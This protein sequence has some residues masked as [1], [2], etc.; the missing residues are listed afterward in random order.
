MKP[1]ALLLTLFV[2]NLWAGTGR[3]VTF[4]SGSPMP[5]AYSASNSQSFI[6]SEILSMSNISLTNSSSYAI[7][8]IFSNNNITPVNG[9]GSGI[10]SVE[11][12]LQAS[13][14]LRMHNYV[15]GRNLFC[16][17]STAGPTNGQ[18]TFNAW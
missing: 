6:A 16:K 4:S 17:G 12:F 9:S 2:T 5:T 3:R 10:Q 7:D 13:E 11:I 14:Q 1:L 15:P 8:C 18:L